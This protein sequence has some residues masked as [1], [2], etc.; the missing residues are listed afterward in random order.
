MEILEEM[1]A[2]EEEKGVQSMGYIRA[3]EQALG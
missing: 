3:L 1:L 2:L